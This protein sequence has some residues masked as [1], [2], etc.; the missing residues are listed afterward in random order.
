MTCISGR[1]CWWL[2]EIKL[3]KRD[4]TENRWPKWMR[5]RSGGPKA[6]IDAPEILEG[7]AGQWDG[8]SREG[9][10]TGQD[11]ALILRPCSAPSSSVHLPDGRQPLI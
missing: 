9:L 8:S 6:V 10:L 2:P 7:Q 11:R 3:E 4:T 5:G 1:Q